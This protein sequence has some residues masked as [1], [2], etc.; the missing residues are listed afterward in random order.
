MSK[1]LEMDVYKLAKGVKH[2]KAFLSR[3]GETTI[4]DDLIN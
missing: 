4:M 2:W 1:S 3:I